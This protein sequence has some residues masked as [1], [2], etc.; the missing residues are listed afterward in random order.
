RSGYT[1]CTTGRPVCEE[2]SMRLVKVSAPQGK[3]SELL[4]IAFACGIS[5]LSVHAVQ[6][7]KAGSDPV[8]RDVIDAQVSD[9][10]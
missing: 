3:A 6:Q 2:S 7:H 10:Q 1:P 9:F 4:K 5:E 8:A